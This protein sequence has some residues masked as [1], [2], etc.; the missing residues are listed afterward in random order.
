LES[1]N[2]TIDE[3][4][5]A[6][7]GRAVAQ[8]R[9]QLVGSNDSKMSFN[10]SACSSISA[11]PKAN[12]GHHDRIVILALLVGVIAC[13]GWVEFFKSAILD[14]RLEPGMTHKPDDYPVA[15]PNDFRWD[16]T[17]KGITGK[18]STSSFV[19]YQCLLAW[20]T[21]SFTGLLLEFMVGQRL[22]AIADTITEQHEAMWKFAQF[23]FPF[24]ILIGILLVRDGNALGMVFGV[25]GMW[26]FGF[27]ETIS[28]KPQAIRLSSPETFSYQTVVF[29]LK[30]YGKLVHHSSS[31]VFFC[32]FAM[33]ASPMTRP[34]TAMSLP[35]VVQHLMVPWKYVSYGMYAVIETVVEV[36]FEMEVFANIEY[37]YYP[38]GVSGA[39]HVYN[40]ILIRGIIAITSAHWFYFTAGIIDIVGKK[41]CMQERKHSGG[42]AM[43]SP[44]MEKRSTVQG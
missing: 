40:P 25:I 7:L 42:H 36:W 29:Y 24:M 34:F 10:I 39:Q 38:H 26:K 6:H 21:C 20:F 35:L 1:I 9:F 17:G 23:L 27:P 22:I 31:M 12:A 8:E 18:W 44:T 3:E 41:C 30:S 19:T 2:L 37:L 43:A 5:D 4:K 33:G 28:I 32:V 15:P 13:I 11:G 14:P 16:W